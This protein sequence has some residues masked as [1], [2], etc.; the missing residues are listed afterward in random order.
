MLHTPI[1]ER[2]ESCPVYD[3]NWICSPPS[4]LFKGTVWVSVL[5]RAWASAG[6]KQSVCL[7][8]ETEEG[9]TKKDSP[10]TP[11]DTNL[12]SFLSFCSFACVI[13]LCTVCVRCLKMWRLVTAPG[14]GRLRAPVEPGSAEGAASTLDHWDSSLAP[15]NNNSYIWTFWEVSVRHQ[16]CDLMHTR[17]AC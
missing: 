11:M 4:N 5:W 16:S 14:A 9:I 17:Q 12:S 8:L 1:L 15:T 2:S 6:A 13:C 7:G 3:P 10:E